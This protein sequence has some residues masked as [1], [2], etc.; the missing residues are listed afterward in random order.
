[1]SQPNFYIFLD[2]DGVLYDIPWLMSEF[3]KGNT[4]VRDHKHFKPE[5]MMALNHLIS[6][7]QEEYN[8]DLVI[9]STWRSDLEGTI[10]T[11]KDNGLSFNGKVN[12]TGFAKSPYFRGNEILDYLKNK[13]NSDNF[14]VIDDETFNFPECFPASKIIKTSYEKGSLSLKMVNDFLEEISS[15]NDIPS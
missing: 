7:L 10:K 4:A 3:D 6:T 2:I 8:V 13:P 9:S 14:V 1:M 11:L 5:S 15:P 12:R